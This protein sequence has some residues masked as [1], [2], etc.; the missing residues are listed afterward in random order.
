MRKYHYTIQEWSID[1]GY[2]IGELTASSTET[3]QREDEGV[4]Y[5]Y[6]DMSTSLSGN[7]SCG[8][9]I[10]I[11]GWV[12]ANVGVSSDR[13]VYVEA[14]VTP[15]MHASVSLGLDGVSA[16]FGLDKNDVSHDIELRLGWGLT[17]F[18]FAPELMNSPQGG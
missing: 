5:S 12:G 4:L 9:G 2:W 11:S 3:L 15:W 6:R 7:S 13:N 16:S 17:I 8:V 18:F 14:Q 1:F 10:N